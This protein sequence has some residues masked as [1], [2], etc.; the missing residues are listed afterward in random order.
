MRTR[1]FLAMAGMTAGAAT[2]LAPTA[3]YATSASE[4]KPTTP[5]ATLASAVGDRVVEAAYAELNSDHKMEVGGSNCNF[6]SGVWE[7]GTPCNGGSGYRAQAWC[8]DF[9]KYVWKNADVMDWRTLGSE[10]GDP[11]RWGQAHGSWFSGTAGLQPGDA[12]VY[13]RDGNPTGGPDNGADHTGIYVGVVNGRQM[14]IS[15]NYSNQV[16]KHGL[17][18]HSSPV[19]GY[20][21]P[22][23]A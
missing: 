20:A 1:T 4:T 6:Y 8:A 16:Y 15:G 13:D 19:R 18:D 9:V 7:R 2:V 10:A 17:H 12:V 23:P 21:R 11:A 5:D 14:V 22:K 3:V